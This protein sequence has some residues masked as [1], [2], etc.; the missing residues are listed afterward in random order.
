MASTLGLLPPGGYS[1]V[2]VTWIPDKFIGC[3]WRFVEMSLSDDIDEVARRLDFKRTI[4]H[5]P[6]N[7]LNCHQNWYPVGIISAHQ[8][9]RQ[10]VWMTFTP[11][12]PPPFQIRNSSVVW[13]RGFVQN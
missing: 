6:V 12:G 3:S 8:R 4:P 7:R 5:Y 2:A 9:Q 10:L 11:T 13:K 1:V